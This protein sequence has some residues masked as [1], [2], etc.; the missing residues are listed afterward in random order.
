MDIRLVIDRLLSETPGVV[1]THRVQ[2]M[3][4]PLVIDRLLAETPGVVPTHRV[5]GMDIPLVIHR[6]LSE[7]Y[8]G[9]REV[10]NSWVRIPAQHDT[11]K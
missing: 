9:P 4:I 3:A 5:Q 10:C 6:L 8:Y 2:S 11:L 1:P 7:T